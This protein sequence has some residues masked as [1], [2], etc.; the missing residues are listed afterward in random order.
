MR[1]DADLSQETK[2]FKVDNKRG[3]KPKK[4][5]MEVKGLGL[6]PLKTTPLGLPSVDEAVLE[7]LAG[8]PSRGE[9]GK[10]YNHFASK[11]N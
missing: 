2:I 11:G 10:A 4:I 1:K 7:A 9:Y 3:T 6:K 8:D 5:D